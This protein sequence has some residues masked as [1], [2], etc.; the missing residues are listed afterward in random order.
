[1]DLGRALSDAMFVKD[2]SSKACFVI[3]RNNSISLPV[4]PILGAFVF[5]SRQEIIVQMI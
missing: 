5:F 1:M 4:Q 2:Q 3:T